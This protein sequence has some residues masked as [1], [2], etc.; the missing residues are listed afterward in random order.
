VPYKRLP[1]VASGL[2]MRE[3]TGQP[4]IEPGPAA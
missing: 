4:P 3:H 2:I 1:E